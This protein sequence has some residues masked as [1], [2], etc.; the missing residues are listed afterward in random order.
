MAFV[1]EVT[2]KASAGKGGDGVVRWLHLKGKER[3]GPAGGD[4]GKGGDVIL[5][6]VRDLGALA[7]FRFLKSIRG[8]NGESGSSNNKY[9]A[10]GAPAI[11]RVPVGTIATDTMT[12]Q[13]F[14]ILGEGQQKVIFK[15]GAGGFGNAHFKG[16]TNQNPKEATPGKQGQAG[17]LSITLKIIA[18]VGFVG[19]PNAG[20]SSLLNALTR[21]RSKVG[22][23]PFTTLDPHLGDFYG[24]L[25]ADIPGLIEGASSGRGLGSKFLRHVERTKYIAHLISVEQDDVVE[26]YN[27]IRTE[28]EAFGKELGEKHEIVILTKTDAVS[29]EVVD[30]KRKALEKATGREVYTVTILDDEVLK[31]F[32]D[33][34]A[35]LLASP[36]ED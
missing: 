1:D 12:G 36:V 18:D 30:A 19:Y 27:N 5:E 2:I 4:G 15:G 20:K 21:A 14:E 24:F 11:L 3:A 6:G 31:D 7:A 16:S 9:G 10:D 29:A 8:Q 32:S 26:A 33:R 34:L 28:L 25:L 22:A 23:Y 35:K 17:Q 13:T